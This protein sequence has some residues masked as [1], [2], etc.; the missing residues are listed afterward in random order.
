MSPAKTRAKINSTL[1]TASPSPTRGGG[2]PVKGVT[3]VTVK[4]KIVQK[5]EALGL[6]EEQVEL[7]HLRVI[8]GEMDREKT[9]VS[10]LQEDNDLL[11]EEL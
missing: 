3:Q 6:T 11:K 4:S 9:V 2:S 8:V 1:N 5:F 10:S 7:N